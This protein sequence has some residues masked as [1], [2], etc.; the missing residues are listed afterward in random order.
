LVLHLRR[1]AIQSVVL[2][3]GQMQSYREAAEEEL[4]EAVG[5]EVQLRDGREGNLEVGALFA[6]ERVCRQHQKFLI[7]AESQSQSSSD[8]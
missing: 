3:R 5:V 7:T 2:L 6:A 4:F 8:L 1:Y